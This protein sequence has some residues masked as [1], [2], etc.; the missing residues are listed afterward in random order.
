VSNGSFGDF[1]KLFGCDAYPNVLLKLTVGQ[2]DD[3]PRLP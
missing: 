2:G 3:S 1:I